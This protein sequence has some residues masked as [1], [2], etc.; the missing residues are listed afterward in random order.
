MKYLI[1]RESNKTV[2]EVVQTSE[3]ALPMPL[4]FVLPGKF[5]KE[6][7]EMDA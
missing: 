2:Q 7:H 1:V 3:V 5:L 4:A 6:V